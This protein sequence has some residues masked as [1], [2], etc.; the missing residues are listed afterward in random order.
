MDFPGLVGLNNFRFRLGEMVV[1]S[2]W[3][4]EPFVGRVVHREIVD[5]GGH[6]FGKY[7]LRNDEGVTLAFGGDPEALRRHET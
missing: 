6:R 3:G 7:W 4:S 2:S 5:V 1:G